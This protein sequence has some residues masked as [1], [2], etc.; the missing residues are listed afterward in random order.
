[1][2]LN[3]TTLLAAAL[4]GSVVPLTLARAEPSRTHAAQP[5]ATH[6]AASAAKEP[7]VASA[8]K[9]ASAAKD[10]LS[11][12]PQQT[13]A[14]FGDWTLRCTHTAAAQLC[15]VTQGVNNQDRPFAQVAI[16]RPG[17]GKPLQM[18]ILVPPSVSL[19]RAAALMPGKDG[20]AMP[21]KDGTAMPGKDGTA[22]LIELAWRRCLPGGCVADTPLPPETLNRIRGL[23]SPA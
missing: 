13:T 9:E 2:R 7:P 19:A 4:L 23:A 18:A 8:A 20:A 6:P 3:A 16:G 22:P 14:T 5:A 12:E 17:K 11:A 10:A 1:M 15:E 21:G